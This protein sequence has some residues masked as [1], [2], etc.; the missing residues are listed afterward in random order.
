M[1][2]PCDRRGRSRILL[3]GPAAP[4]R[5]PSWASPRGHTP[6]WSPLVARRSASGESWTSGA[7]RAPRSPGWPARRPR[8]CGGV[9]RPHCDAAM[10][11]S[12][13]NDR[14][15]AAAEAGFSPS[16]NESRS[17]SNEMTRSIIKSFPGIGDKTLRI[18]ES[19]G[20]IEIVQGNGPSRGLAMVRVSE[21][22]EAESNT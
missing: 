22:S 1:R 9:L 11:A 21:L 13:P 4:R 20:R 3:R 12:P 7:R 8:H 6:M 2:Q 16:A 19:A 15:A 14:V 10:T 5:R 17:I 18:R